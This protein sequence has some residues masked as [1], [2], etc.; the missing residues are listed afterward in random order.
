MDWQTVGNWIKD[1]AGSGAALVG[2]LLTG[3][4]PAA[5]AA[6]VS[7]V[8]TA[9]GTNNPA[10]ALEALQTDPTTV[11]KLKEL[12]NAN[13]ADVRRHLEAMHLAELQDAQAEQETTA[14]VTISGDNSQDVVV[15]RTRPLQSW[16]SLVGALVYAFTK[17]SPDVTILGLLLTLP[18]AYAGLRQI[19]KGI[20]SWSTAR[21]TKAP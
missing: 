10:K 15:R 11:V 13:E 8:G 16:L 19:G 7:M 5:V 14:K 3:N 6:G 1:N 4:V 21:A 9:T 18:W 12:A 17:E 20:D 2:A